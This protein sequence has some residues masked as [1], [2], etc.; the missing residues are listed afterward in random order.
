MAKWQ[1]FKH[2][3]P[4]SQI[5]SHCYQAS[6]ALVMSLWELACNRFG[7]GNGY[8]HTPTFAGRPAPTGEFA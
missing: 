4:L 5:W 2:D 7:P 8:C 6:F 3:D 1:K